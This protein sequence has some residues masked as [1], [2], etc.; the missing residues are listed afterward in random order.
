MA[1]IVAVVREMVAEKEVIVQ[2]TRDERG[3]ERHRQMEWG[4][5]V[6]TDCTRVYYALVNDLMAMRM[7]EWLGYDGDYNL[8]EVVLL[9]RKLSNVVPDT[10]QTLNSD[11]VGDM[12]RYLIFAIAEEHVAS[13]DGNASSIADLEGMPSWRCPDPVAGGRHEGRTEQV[14]RSS[15]RMQLQA[16]G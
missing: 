5:G 16:H 10:W 11:V 12:V 15:L 14:M 2:E 4:P 3:S 7:A 8:M 1:D 9:V 6:Q 13:M